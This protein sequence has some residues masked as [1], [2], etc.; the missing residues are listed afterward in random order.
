MEKMVIEPVNKEEDVN[1]GYKLALC[2][3]FQFLIF[4]EYTLNYHLDLRIKIIE[5]ELFLM[6]VLLMY[7]P[8]LYIALYYDLEFTKRR[9]IF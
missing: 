2:I 9:K 7:R 4:T 1:T 8:S 5:W 3:L 6:L